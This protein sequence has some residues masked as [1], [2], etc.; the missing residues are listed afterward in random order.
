VALLTR[1]DDAEMAQGQRMQ[2]GGEEEEEEEEEKEQQQH[3]QNLQQPLPHRH[4]RLNTSEIPH[5]LKVTHHPIPRKPS[6]ATP[7]PDPPPVPLDVSTP[8]LRAPMA[9]EQSAARVKLCL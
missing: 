8:P 4:H 3:H 1:D 5:H 7:P 6:A 2:Q 9:C